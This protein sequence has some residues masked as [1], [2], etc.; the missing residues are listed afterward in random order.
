MQ[1]SKITSTDLE[2]GDLTT[3]IKLINR[4]ALNKIGK[5]T[6]IYEVTDSDGNT[7]INNG[8]NITVKK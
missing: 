8:L 2:D 7:A 4:D 6:L 1:D 3:K 5:Q